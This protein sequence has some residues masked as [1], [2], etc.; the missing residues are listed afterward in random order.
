MQQSRSPFQSLL[1]QTTHRDFPVPAGPPV[2]RQTWERLLF[3]NYPIAPE[4]LQPYLPKGLE[5]DIFDGQAWLSIVPFYLRMSFTLLPEALW[6]IAFPELNVR[7]YVR[8]N[9]HPA[10]Y[11]FSLDTPDWFSVQAAR[12]WFHLNYFKSEINWDVSAEVETV[13]IQAARLEAPHPGRFT[14]QYTPTGASEILPGPG[15]LEHFLL[16]RWSF[17]AEVMG[18]P[19]RFCRGDIHHEPW[20]IQPAALSITENTLF[21]GHGLPE[22]L[23][24]ESVIYAPGA[25]ILAWNRRYL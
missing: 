11:F 16:S 6:P 10:V 20:R 5:V 2:S 9:G 12:F 1:A 24:L 18:K 3:L 14:A 4:R 15:T 21:A 7:T 23:P 17:F 25:H 22:G 13:R 8:C 19:G